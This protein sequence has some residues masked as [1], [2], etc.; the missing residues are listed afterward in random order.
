VAHESIADELVERIVARARDIRMGDP[1]APDTEMG[2]L[3]NERQLE[4][5][6]GFIDRA[7]AAGATVATGGRV[8]PEHGGLFVEPTVLS[9]VAPDSEIAREEV[10]GPVLATST[11]STEDEAV[12]IANGTDYGLGAGVWTSHVGRAHRIAHRLRAGTV[13]VNSYRV[14]APNMPF[15]GF[16][17]SGWGRENGAEAVREYTD[18]KAVWVELDGATRDPFRMG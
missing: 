9:D 8:S 7:A 15:G 18:T 4:T 14:I 16:G 10:F 3:A 11:F 2:P 6:M 1:M 13:W 5:V 12:A 17:A